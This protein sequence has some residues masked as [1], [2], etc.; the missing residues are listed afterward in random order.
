MISL[1][2]KSLRHYRR[3]HLA[4][5]A[6]VFIASSVLTGA[7]SV[8]D[9][10][11]ATLARTSDQRLG[12]IDSALVGNERFF[13]SGYGTSIGGVP[14][15]Q[16]RGSA[17]TPDGRSRLNNMQVIGAP[18]EFWTQIGGVEAPTLAPGEAA[19]NTTVARRLNV[20]AGDTIIVRVEKPGVISRDAP[21]S[22]S[23]DSND[24]TEALNVKVA[25]VLDGDA[26]GN[27][28]LKS[29]Q[30]APLNVFVPYESLEESLE[31][32]G[33]ANLTLFTGP[34]PTR[35][36]LKKEWNLSDAGL[37]LKEVEG[38]MQLAS[39]RVL[40]EPRTA[41]IVRALKPDAQGVM[42]YLVNKIEFANR[43]TPYSMV[44]AKEGMGP[45]ATISQWLADDLQV[46]VG[47]TLTLYYFVLATGR[48]LEETS[49]EFK[50]ERV[51]PMDHPDLHP[52]WSPEFPG[53]S[54]ADNC[55]DWNPGIPVDL[56]ALRDKDE[57]YWDKYKATP[58]IFI[59]LEDGQRMWGNR[60]GNLTAMRLG[61]TPADAADFEKQLAARIGPGDFGVQA[62]PVRKQARAA[63]RDSLD[64]GQYLA[65]F[66][67]FLI[68]AALLLTALLFGLSLDHR[69][70]QFGTLLA[71]GFTPANVR[72]LAMWE[73]GLVSFAGATLGILGGVVFTRLILWLLA[74][75]WSS[76][77]GGMSFVYAPGWKSLVF[78]ALAIHI[79]AKIV[80]WFS[81]RRLGKIEPARLLSGAES[82][83]TP[84]PKRK[85]R[86][87]WK[88]VSFW[89]IILGVLGALGNL[90]WGLKADNP[91]HMA[92][93]FY[94]AGNFL[95][96]G[97]IAALAFFLARV[98]LRRTPST[99]LAGFG[100]RNSARRRGRSL[101]VVLIMA[102]G[103][104]IVCAINAF[105]LNG[106]AD[107]DN[108]AS[109][110]G[111]FALVG[112]SATPIYEN[113]DSKTGRA[114]LNI[115]D[116][117]MEFST[118][119]FRVREG[120]EASCLNL[121]RAQRP[122]L[123]GVD[124]TRLSSLDAFTFGAS[125]LSADTGN[126]WDLL[127][128]KS[129]DETVPGIM[130]ANS[131]T[132]AMG[133]K[134]GDTI[135]YEDENGG[136]FS[137]QIV[138][139]LKNSL[140]QGSV[141]VSDSAFTEKFG[142][143]GGYR[144][145]LIDSATEKS[146][147]LKEELTS[148][149]R[150]RGLELQSAPERLAEFY[151]VQNTYL[152]I[153]STLGGLGLLLGTAGLAI[154]MLR[155]LLERRSELALL[156]ASGFSRK[157]AAKLALWE[158]WFLHITAVALGFVAALIAVAPALGFASDDFPLGLLLAIGAGI[159]LT[160]IICCWAAARLALKYPLLPALR[161]E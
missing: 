120:E 17:A 32:S 39:R 2:W 150:D 97:G 18:P 30:V 51:L 132:Y 31:K 33:R 1:A 96:L 49:A 81:S 57:E 114:A 111:G 16:T 71:L 13:R 70:Q 86:P 64:L 36:K 129:D 100:L 47:D 67:F 116:L 21:L 37:F 101:A 156:Q 74:T 125:E 119:P 54:D 137:V 40:F 117:E 103:V 7:L 52:D 159:L 122:R 108:R 60:F 29:E 62:V 102:L 76:A 146:T 155:N 79:L 149:L 50:I 73:G 63:V 4:V 87:F 124:H 141:I 41:E 3:S 98:S 11:R 160:G 118:V 135:S 140:L 25:T 157:Q 42:T 136:V 12:N 8:G 80:L 115:D 43:S 148:A 59:G 78:G 138:G 106:A 77:G 121:N 133:L 72:R 69:R 113:L 56:K 15:L 128:Y 34:L 153:I 142:S 89:L 26:F 147:E 154:L 110:T 28:S 82:Y 5:L 83:E 46:D 127:A 45:G 68:V 94:G 9:S 6:G 93:A 48:K 84:L 92:Y 55:R 75:V 14:V 53:V 104:F 27:Y 44:T 85:P 161:S 95:L 152:K 130:D 123:M 143:T 38:E 151:A 99:S 134:L 10:V 24:T 158:H 19:V 58:K 22:G 20:T 107:A 61:V 139:L 112:Q 126:A 131:A 66:S 23:T 105:R 109:G 90:A 35:D 88:Y 91:E 65:A 144:Y 145:F